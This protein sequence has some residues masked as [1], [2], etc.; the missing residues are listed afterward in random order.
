MDRDEERAGQRHSG[1]EEDLHREGRQGDRHR[2]EDELRVQ[3]SE[4]E[5]RTDTRASAKPVM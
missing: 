2:D 3:R 5:L 1:K 4:E